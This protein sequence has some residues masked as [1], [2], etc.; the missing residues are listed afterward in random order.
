MAIS[1][2]KK[3]L[4]ID[5]DKRNVFAL[6]VVLR[7][8]GYTSVSAL[9]AEEGLSLLHQCNDISI[10]LLDMMMPEMDGYTFM[11]EIRSNEG[12][13]QM[14]LIAVTAQ[15]MPGDKERCLEAGADAYLSKP[16]DVDKLL[17][18]LNDFKIT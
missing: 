12:L 6:S 9:S 8:R 10:V 11:S 18:I 2:D 3:I 5:D 1:A 17:D 15:A 4:I 16:I 7:A 14:P 13:A